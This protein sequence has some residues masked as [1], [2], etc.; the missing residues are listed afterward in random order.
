[1][2]CDCQCFQRPRGTP[3][4]QTHSPTQIYAHMHIHAKTQAYISGKQ[5]SE[6]C[7]QLKQNE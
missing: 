6:L 7:Y 5:L 1:M 2:V 4:R 3:H